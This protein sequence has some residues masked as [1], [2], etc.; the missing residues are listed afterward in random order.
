MRLSPA[1]AQHL[2]TSDTPKLLARKTLVLSSS[3]TQQPFSAKLQKD[4]SGP[5]STCPLTAAVPL[6]SPA[7]LP[8][9]RS[10]GKGTFLD[11]SQKQLSEQRPFR[12]QF[13]TDR[14]IGF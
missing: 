9:L 3:S 1:P 14:R 7:V 8:G 11:K 13:L 6:A 5:A 2:D 12:D 10:V 4:V